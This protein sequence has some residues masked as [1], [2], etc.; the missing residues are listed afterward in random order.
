M[1]DSDTKEHNN[2]FGEA[3]IG[4]IV[5]VITAFILV[6]STI[7]AIIIFRHRRKKYSRAVLKSDLSANRLNFKLQMNSSAASNGKLSRGNV[8]KS[9]ATNEL[10]DCEKDVVKGNVKMATFCMSD[11][12][13]NQLASAEKIP[14]YELP[15]ISSGKSYCSGE[16]SLALYLCYTCSD[17][18][19]VSYIGKSVR[20]MHL[21]REVAGLPKVA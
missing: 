17:T 2:P 16:Q 18:C 7:A 6:T 5:G 15:N 12:E 8:Y 11:G 21:C 10:L 1:V 9:I 20:P 14:I 4:V 13:Y 19:P 3:H